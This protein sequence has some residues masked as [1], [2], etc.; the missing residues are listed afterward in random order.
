M[1]VIG[2]DRPGLVQAVAARVADHGGN[3][4]ESRMCRLGGQFAGILRVEVPA[5]R[6]DELVT[7]LNVVRNAVERNIREAEEQDR[8]ETRY[9]LERDVRW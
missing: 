5:N 6:R 9:W 3:W 8:W 1:T 2:P 4:L 7:A